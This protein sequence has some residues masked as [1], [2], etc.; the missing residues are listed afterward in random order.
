MCTPTTSDRRSIRQSARSVFVAS[1]TLARA[2]SIL[3]FALLVAPGRLVVRA[4]PQSRPGSV[5]GIDIQIDLE[6]QRSIATLGRVLRATLRRAVATWA[7]M[8]LPVH[9]IVVGAGFPAEGKA[10]IY[11]SFT[12]GYSDQVDRR[13]VVISLGLRNGDRD[14]EPFELAGALAAQIQRVIDDV[15]REHARVVLD[16]SALLSAT[17][18]LTPPPAVG[19]ADSALAATH[20][21]G[22]STHPS[23]MGGENLPRLPEL[24]ATV[25]E[26][27]HSSRGW[28]CIANH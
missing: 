14:L 20:A 10:D 6:D 13:L 21:N 27:S 2:L 12:P 23:G 22:A 7:P 28:P 19:I 15:H 3:A 9:R 25:Q 18:R 11:D 26:A 5:G 24:L 4:R 1:W 16:A 8:V 17:S